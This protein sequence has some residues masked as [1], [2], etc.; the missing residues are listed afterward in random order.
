M[1][2]TIAQLP[3]PATPDELALAR[4]LW[5]GGWSTYCTAC[6]REGMAARG[7]TF[8]ELDARMLESWVAVA[9]YVRRS[10]LSRDRVAAAFT[11]KKSHE[12][13]ADGLAADL[14]DLKGTTCEDAYVRGYHD[15]IDELALE[16]SVA[17][18]QPAKGGVS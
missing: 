10:Y 7:L 17:A 5:E 8:D 3:A 9:R 12:F 14:G 6:E 16:L 18:A 4:L 13:F 11:D 15:A 2:A 1:N